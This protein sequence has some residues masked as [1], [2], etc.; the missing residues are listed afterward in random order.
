MVPQPNHSAPSIC[1]ITGRTTHAQRPTPGSLEEGPR[2]WNHSD[3]G[4]GRRGAWPS[5]N[6]SLTLAHSRALILD[7]SGR[8]CKSH[9]RKVFLCCFP[10]IE[11]PREKCKVQFCATGDRLQFLRNSQSSSPGPLEGHRQAH[12]KELNRSENSK[13][14][15]QFSTTSK[16]A[17]FG[18]QHSTLVVFQ[19]LNA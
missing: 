18:K 1:W 11:S 7:V 19:E 2:K 3:S 14:R 15:I 4:A 9:A 10:R 6:G 13:I 16:T 12:H 17:I 5:P 8:T